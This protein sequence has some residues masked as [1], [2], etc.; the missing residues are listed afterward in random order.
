MIK[1]KTHLAQITK[2]DWN[3]TNLQCL[4]FRTTMKLQFGT[5]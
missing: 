3:V 1:G 5:L 2:A 4:F